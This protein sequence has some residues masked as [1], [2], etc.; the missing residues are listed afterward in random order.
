M[1]MWVQSCSM[2]TNQ[3]LNQYSC[4]EYVTGNGGVFLS[5]ELAQLPLWKMKH[6]VL[7]SS[8]SGALY[9]M[10]HLPPQASPSHVLLV[11]SFM[12]MLVEYRCTEKR[13]NIVSAWRKKGVHHIL[14]VLTLERQGMLTHFSWM[15]AEYDGVWHYEQLWFSCLKNITLLF[16]CWKKNPKISTSDLLKHLIPSNLSIAS[17]EVTKVSLVINHSNNQ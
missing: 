3:I 14:Q 9:T 16:V 13:H 6:K 2:Y 11:N 12:L 10:H 7:F 17:P 5:T 8:F 1:E 15:L 4:L